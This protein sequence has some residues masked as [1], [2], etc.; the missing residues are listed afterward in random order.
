MFV[1]STRAQII[2][3]RTYNRPLNEEGTEFETW[4]QTIDRVIS[5]QKWLWERALT[6]KSW[7]DMPLNDITE[8]M[9]EWVHLVDSQL[10]ELA[11]LRDLLLERKVAVAGRTL[12]LGGTNIAKT[13]AMSQFNCFSKDT[14]F[15]TNLG[16]KSFSDYSDGD[17]VQV[18][19]DKGN[20]KPAV[21]KQYGSQ[22]LNS[23][24]FNRLTVQY[25]VNATA[26]HRWILANGKETTNLKVGDKVK[27][28][29]SSFYDWNWDT[30]DN[31][32]K[33][34]WIQGFLYGDGALDNWG[35]S[36]VRLCGNKSRFLSRFTE[37]DMGHS[38]PESCKGDPFVYC[39]K[40]PKELIYD[41]D[42]I[43]SFV[44]G[45]LDADGEIDSRGSTTIFRSIQQTSTEAQK[46]LE[47]FLPLAGLYITK[48]QKASDSTNFG[49]R[50]NI[51]YRYF[52]SDHSY[53]EFK[54]KSITPFEEQEVW[55]LEVEDDLSFTL[56]SGITTGNCAAINAQTVHDI[57][58]I[59]WGLLN[60]SGMGFR[61]VPGT[62]TGFRKVIPKVTFIPSTR[63]ADEKGT[64]FNEEYMEDGIWYIRVGDSAIAWAKSVGKILAGK[65][66]AKELIIDFSEIRGGGK[67]LRNYGWLSQGSTGL[68]KSYKKIVDIMNKRADSL[69]SSIDILDVVNLL[70]TVL[71]TRR[72]AQ[73]AI[74]DYSSPEWELF[75]R[76]KSHIFSNDGSETGLEHRT[77]S[78]NSIL[79]DSKPSKKELSSLLWMMHRGGKGE[80]GLI[81]GVELKRRAPWATLMNPC[82]PEYVNLLTKQGIKQLKDISIGDEVFSE[83]GWVIVENK[84]STGIKPVFRYST[85]AGN[86]DLTSNHRVKSGGIKVEVGSAESIDTISGEVVRRLELEPQDV[87]DGLVFGDGFFH[88]ASNRFTLCVG[89]KDKDTYYNSEIA[90]YLGDLKVYSD[91]SDGTCSVKT[92]LLQ[93]EVDKTYDKIVPSRFFYGSKEKVAGFLRGIYSAN[94]SVIK[95]AKRVTFKTASK[96]LV[97]QLSKMLSFLGIK[98]YYTTNKPTNVKFSNG[99]YTCKESYDLNITSHRT[100]FRDLVGFLHQY[101]MDSLNDICLSKC[102]EPKVT[103]DIKESEYLGDMEVYD[104]TVSGPSHT[105]WCEGFNISNCAEILLPSKGGT[106]NL[107]SI[108]LGKFKGSNHELHDAAR[109]I[110]RAN[111]RQTCV[112]FRDGILQES[113]SLNSD[114]L[115][116][117]GVSLMGVAKRPDMGAYEYRT[118]RRHQTSAAYSMAE[119]LDLPYPKNISTIKPE[120]TQSKCYDSTEG[121]HKPL[122][123]YIFNNVAFS[124]HDPLID[125]LRKANYRVFAHPYDTTAMLV[126]LPISY[127]DVKFD[128]VDGKEVNLESAVDQL[129]RYKMLMDNYCDQNVSCTIS[130]D[131][132]ELEDI[133]DWLYSNW[134]SYVAVSFLKRNDPSKTA[135]DLGYPYLPQEVVTEA[136][137]LEYT[138][139]LLDINLDSS[140]SHEELLEEGCSGGVCPIR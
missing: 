12:W 75:A 111:Y 56:E 69:L 35:N 44:R 90:E 3:R 36:R 95:S 126:T 31:S 116:L 37:F 107:V 121:M 38:Y 120:G 4:E 10:E 76:A 68:M 139:K 51:T 32:K 131:E 89:A 73:I 42:L 102:R 49:K 98:S 84:W 86:I 2:T 48:A 8:D 33:L 62:L 53:G 26:N 50:S 97:L 71:S 128:V 54:V 118:L 82:M 63:T 79:F 45:L 22:S 28:Q 1:P 122:G 23:I 105:F 81:N 15:V 94:G 47:E 59:F 57:V 18:L 30:L 114:H 5:H 11:Q 19:T 80:P 91:R 87:L 46:Y 127:E 39:G 13:I 6:Q 25:T 106:C 74:M 58:D 27:K 34:A 43:Q 92:T 136:E 130:Y 40:V 20:W 103:Y 133:T 125:I 113:W 61:P 60:G 64:E 9:Q 119:E 67:R 52:I 129:N 101:K 135:K 29:V 16:V 70:G 104:I 137:Y 138:A 65:Y 21:V 100:I 110:S 55:C 7:P 24:L 41:K 83:D 124:I 115:R 93:N 112:D 117:C 123:K 77:Q 17:K 134:D 108:D 66:N 96:E 78:N 85:T 72:S 109:I 88:K 14:K 132:N 99:E 140:N